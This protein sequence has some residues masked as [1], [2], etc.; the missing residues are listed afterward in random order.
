MGLPLSPAGPVGPP[1][2][3]GPVVPVG[4]VLL[5]PVGLVG[6]VTV[7]LCPECYQDGIDDWQEYDVSWDSLHDTGTEGSH[8]ARVARFL[9]DH[10]VE[11]VAAHHM[12]APMAHMLQKMGI[13]VRLG[14]TGNARDAATRALDGAQDIGRPSTPR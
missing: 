3:V 5:V 12:G 7:D 8:H 6:P 9:R 2:V 4:P 14:E 1:A 11:A 13:T 10:H